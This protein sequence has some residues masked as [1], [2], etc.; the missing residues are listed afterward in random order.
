[1]GRFKSY[2]L[3]GAKN[4]GIGF[5]NGAVSNQIGMIGIQWEEITV[6]V[7][8]VLVESVG[9]SRFPCQLNM[10]ADRVGKVT[11]LDDAHR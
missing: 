7:A 4:T 3:T 9:D 10:V 8:R 11:Q 1:M 2:H 5:V 6:F